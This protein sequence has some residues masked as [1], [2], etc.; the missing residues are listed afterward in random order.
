MT[1]LIRL[2][3]VFIL[4]AAWGQSVAPPAFA[5]DN[6]RVTPASAA[7]QIRSLLSQAQLAVLGGTGAA[8]LLDEAQAVYNS[9]LSA[10][11]EANVPQ[12]AASINAAFAG[13]VAE[14][15]GGNGPGFASAATSVWT[16]LLQAAYTRVEVA[17][18][19]NN[20][21]DAQMWLAVREFRQAT[22]FTRPDADATLA[23]AA[24]GRGEIAADA[25]LQS[26]HADLLD[27]YQARMEDAMRLIPETQSQGFM[28][29]YAQQTS[30]AAG[31]F[32][33]LSAQYK[34]QKGA[35]SLSRAQATFD[36]LKQAGIE[37]SDPARLL[38][39]VKTLTSGF[40]AAPLTDVEQGRRAGQLLRFLSLVPIE[41][42][43]GVNGT[44]VTKDIE[45]EEAITF[46][47]G[48]TAALTD[49]LTTLQA[50]D[51]VKT[52]EVQRLMSEQ[53]AKLDA[54]S[55]RT[56]VTPAAEI[57]SNTA[58]TTAILKEIMPEAWL[59]SSPSAD[60]D[61][62]K[63]VLDQMETAVAAGDYTLAQSAR[64]EAYAILEVG[65]EA[66]LR[67]FAPQLSIDIESLFWYGTD[68]QRGLAYLLSN[69][70]PLA[71]VK[72]TR[73]VLDK[74]LVE[75]LE[76]VKG[77]NAPVAVATNASII[78][79]REGL[80]AVL[81]LASLLGSLK[82]G[83]NRRFRKPIWWGVVASLVAT[84]LTFLLARSLLAS[85]ARYGEALEAVVSLVAIAVLLLITNWFFHKVYWTGWI[86]SFHTK[87]KSLIGGEVGQKLGLVALG[88]TSIYR[89]GL[90]TVLFLQALV[91]EGG[92]A[93]VM[94]GV[95]V[96]LAG[97]VLVGI[98]VFTLQAKL[99]YKKMLVA[100]GVMIGFV[101]LIMV[102]NTVHVMQL[103]GWV[104]IHSIPGLEI[105]YWAGMWFGLYNT[106]ETILLQVA[107]GTFVI[108]S[109]F[110]A[111]RQKDRKVEAA[112]PRQTKK[113][114]SGGVVSSS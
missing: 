49:L 23:L 42:G 76:V 69:E 51:P 48:A 35:E 60:I 94:A 93:T 65:P 97:T 99:P 15:A 114:S 80:E 79:F 46:Q 53:T 21:E 91:L 75:A 98:V 44:Q 3:S 106:W 22:R 62:I 89:E 52:A 108:G 31:Y 6:E 26:F 5:Q 36:A 57:E 92:I 61:V 113:E 45:I 96:G 13:A 110:L 71:Q 27:T 7:E 105:P 47:H 50:I 67:V 24:F 10:D 59:K 66:R 38:A 37:G 82:M 84:V 58:G 55:K 68:M 88:F 30:L 28:V 83:A 86:A 56:A 111:E 103:V 104:P 2:L 4:L 19:A 63:S 12:Q 29:R 54:T 73:A 20:A 11:L 17:I 16:S 39:E 72:E 41:Y 109:Y 90:E 81:I 40:R 33:I 100:T 1:R 34:E 78:V 107:A 8:E 43:R 87:K 74:K 77:D 101:L 64:L 14:L 32:G 9:S 70:A 18:G 25:T 112:Q 95:A 85:L 102:G